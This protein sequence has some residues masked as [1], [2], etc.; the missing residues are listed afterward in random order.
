M[1]HQATRRMFLR[2][3]IALAGAG[4]A[5]PALLRQRAKAAAPASELLEDPVPTSRP[6]TTQV[7]SPHGIVVTAHPGGAEAGLK[8]LHDGG[9]AVDAAVA[10]TMALCVTLPSSVGIGGYGGSM[11][12]YL[13]KTG[14]VETIDFDARTP[15][16]CRPE[17]FAGKPR[18]ETYG[19]WRSAFRALSRAS[20]WR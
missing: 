17:I 4:A 20:T 1:G 2:R 8:A 12:V 13:A 10:A 5:V 14:R 16:A 19:S 3:S 15:K 7:S 11:I 6:A 9:N 18:A